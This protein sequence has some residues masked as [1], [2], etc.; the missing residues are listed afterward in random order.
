[1]SPQPLACRRDCACPDSIFHPVC[2][3]NGIEYLSPCHAGCSD[4]NIS[5]AASKQPVRAARAPGDRR[6]LLRS[7]CSVWRPHR[8]LPS[9][10]MGRAHSIPITR[11]LA[12][13]GPHPPPS[14]SL[15][16]CLPPLP[17][18]PCLRSCPCP[19]SVKHWPRLSEFT[20]L[21]QKQ[22]EAL[23]QLMSASLLL[24]DPVGAPACPV[25]PSHATRAHTWTGPSEAGAEGL[26]QVDLEGERQKCH[27]KMLSSKIQPLGVL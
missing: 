6:S 10:G 23:V 22:I 26:C 18:T 15:P 19:K 20:F 5:S 1:M 13:P 24:T 11:V 3:D 16:S 7:Q 25:C 2:G 9:S 8:W 12:S 27:S 17:A 21:K 4:M 14:T